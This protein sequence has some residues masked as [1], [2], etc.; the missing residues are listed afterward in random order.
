LVRGYILGAAIDSGRKDP[1]QWLSYSRN[2]NYYANSARK[3]YWPVNNMYAGVVSSVDQ[4]AGL[5]LIEHQKVPPGNLHWQSRFR[6]RQIGCGGHKAR[7]THSDQDERRRLTG[8]S[9][10]FARLDALN[11]RVPTPP[12]C[13]ID[14]LQDD[15]VDFEALLEGDLA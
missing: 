4:L 13:V 11:R 12:Q 15:V 5:G 10:L 9:S 2:H 8:G 7:R 3:R 14:P 6:A 1:E